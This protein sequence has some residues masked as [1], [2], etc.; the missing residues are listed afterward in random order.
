MTA[1]EVKAEEEMSAAGAEGEAGADITPKRDGGVLKV[2]PGAGGE[3]G[4]RLGRSQRASPPTPAREAGVCAPPPHHSPA[5]GRTGLGGRTGGLRQASKRTRPP[6]RR[7][8]RRGI[9]FLSAVRA[10]GNPC[11]DNLVRWAGGAGFSFCT[12]RGPGSP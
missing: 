2:S 8:N 3:G 1:E 12:R 7:S 4:W 5:G 11:N 6:G 10:L 9:C